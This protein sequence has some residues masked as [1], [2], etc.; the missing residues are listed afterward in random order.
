MFL[1][2]HARK[3]F[4]KQHNIRGKIPNGTS[5]FYHVESR[6]EIFLVAELA[7]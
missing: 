4:R 2:V 3:W 1:R 5:S 6:R 7:A